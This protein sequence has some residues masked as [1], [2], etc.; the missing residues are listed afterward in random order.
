M[1]LA[2]NI[3][4]HAELR[5][6]S[7]LAEEMSLGEYVWIYVLVYNSWLG[8]PPNE[9]FEENSS[10]SFTRKERRVIR[11]LME[12]HVETLTEAGRDDE[13]AVWQSE[14]D[15]IMDTDSGVPFADGGF[16]PAL[17]AVIE[18]LGAKLDAVYCAAT[19]SFEL[20][21]VRKKGLSFHTE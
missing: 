7:L 2:G 12:N 18:P 11:T 5:N 1:G 9:G 17:A 8:H 10:G 4:K 15:R 16:P 6:R 13:A 20:A 3:G 14:I 19:S 21:K